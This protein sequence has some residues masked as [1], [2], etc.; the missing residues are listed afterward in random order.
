MPVLYGVFMYMGVSAIRNMQVCNIKFSS[1]YYKYFIYIYIQIFDR[2]LLIFMPQKY[3]PDFPYLRHVR[4]ARVHLFTFI[5][6]LSLAGMFAVKSV[7]TI[8]IG[9]P[10]LVNSNKYLIKNQIFI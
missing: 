6:I 8:A 5:Q 2:I 4:I 9:F 3:Q 1:I 10:V 7:K